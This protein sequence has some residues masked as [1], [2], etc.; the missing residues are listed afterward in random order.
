M[1]N[2]ISMLLIIALCL[3][4]LTGCGSSGSSES[5]SN[6]EEQ[7]ETEVSAA[8]DSPAFYQSRYVELTDSGVTSSLQNAVVDGDNLYYTSLGVI[9]DRTPEGVTPDWEEQY[10]VYGPILCKVTTDGTVERVPYIP[11]TD[12]TEDMKIVSMTFEQ[13]CKGKDDLLWILEKHVCNRLTENTAETAETAPITETAMA[14]EPAETAENAGEVSAAGTGLS[15]EYYLAGIRK[16]GTLV[17]KVPL[18]NLNSHAD[19]VADA[20]GSYTFKIHGMEQDEKGQICISVS[21]WFISNKN[22]QEDNRICV[23]DGETGNLVQAIP[24][25]NA[26]EQLASLPDGRIAASG[27]SGGT[28]IIGI[29]DAKSAAVTETYPI[30]DS[31]DF[32]TAGPEN[33]IYFSSG[34]TLYCLNTEDGEVNRVLGWTESD[35]LHDSSDCFCF[36]DDQRIVTVHSHDTGNGIQNELIILEPSAVDPASE[37]QTLRLAVM[38]LYPFTSEMVIRFNRSNPN[39]RIEVTDYSQYNDYT[40]DNEDDWNAGVNRLQTEIVAGNA[41]DII[42][43]S[44]LSADR[45]GSSGILADLY[46]MIDADPELNR[47]DL[48]EHVLEAFDEDGKLYQTV[49]NFYILTTAGL[50]DRV[51]NERGWTMNQL[52][53][54][55]QQL[56]SEN[57]DA[58]VFDRFTTADDILTFLLYL[59][60]EDYVDWTTG[61]CRF[62]SDA[63]IGLLEFV[64]SFPK[65]FDWEAENPSLDDL[66][67]DARIL[68]GQQLLKQCN[69]NCFEDA[70]VNTVGFAGAPCTFVG[71]P[72]ED[73]YG[74]MFAQIGNS[75][76][77]TSN[78]KDPDAAWEFVRQFFLPYY[79][80]QFKGIVFP[81][82][83]TV[84]EEMKQLATT[85]Q[86]ERNADGSYAVDKDGNR[87]PADRGFTN[88]NGGIYTY[89]VVTEEEVALVEQMIQATTRVLGMDDSMKAI[90]TEGAAP[91]FAGQRSAEDAAKLIQSKAALYVNEQK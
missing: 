86:Y 2:K 58:T 47:S 68:S 74:S 37:K 28:P 10:W 75:F 44:L 49:S 60:L 61:E 56:R 36:L 12:N 73:G 82:N 63:F 41:P 34:D 26:A 32:L 87:K 84:Y 38:N 21:E 45:F 27:Y 11:E 67:S 7:K 91:F 18:S 85:V 3:S 33:G 48:A 59:E 52:L 1:K 83:K 66:D 72:T 71:Y 57:P 53:N 78:C 16:D 25:D 17:S 30:S 31:V 40:S 8:S 22:F 46:P 55:M 89:H 4:F 15:E 19:S 24:L 54:A 42:G 50:S 43:I 65:A 76:A 5:S 29:I 9:E 51:G 69:F 35:V 70:Q 77:I 6:S 64:N 81:T 20:E 23:I 79:Q 62:D 14:A 80:E 88:L 13:M 39:Y 90:I